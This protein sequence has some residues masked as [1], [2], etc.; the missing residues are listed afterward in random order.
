MYGYIVHVLW[1]KIHF[2]LENR[3]ND[4]GKAN[5]QIIYFMM[6]VI[7]WVLN[8]NVEWLQIMMNAK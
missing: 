1:M 8:N 6:L 7:I 3:N 4:N 5:Q 2:K